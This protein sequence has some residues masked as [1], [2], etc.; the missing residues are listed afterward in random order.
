MKATMGDYH[1]HTGG[2]YCDG[3]TLYQSRNSIPT[4]FA[5]FVTFSRVLGVFSFLVGF[6]VFVSV[7]LVFL[8]YFPDCLQNGAFFLVP[9]SRVLG[10]FRVFLVFLTF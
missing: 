5:F 10:V 7:S 4:L 8:V 1:I 9:F 3:M 6:S 2:I